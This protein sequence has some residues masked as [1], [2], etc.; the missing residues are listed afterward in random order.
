[1]FENPNRK[2][3]KNLDREMNK[4][5]GVDSGVDSLSFHGV[6]SVAGNSFSKK[7]SVQ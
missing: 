7:T 5:H 4:K 2:I 3:D 1:M 6:D